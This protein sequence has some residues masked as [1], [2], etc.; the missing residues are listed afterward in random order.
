MESSWRPANRY[1]TTD[2]DVFEVRGNMAEGVRTDRT[3]N[4]FVINIPSGTGADWINVGVYE[5]KKDLHI[6][7]RLTPEQA[8]DL[9][10]ALT[11][12]AYEMQGKLKE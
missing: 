6:W 11:Y 9:A 1:F 3:D 7:V 12:Y 8:L 10:T 5:G 4:G 2:N